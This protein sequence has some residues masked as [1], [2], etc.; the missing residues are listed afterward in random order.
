[1]KRNSIIDLNQIVVKDECKDMFTKVDIFRDN[2]FEQ[3]S[4]KILIN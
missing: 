4:D 1:L 3:Y 2:A